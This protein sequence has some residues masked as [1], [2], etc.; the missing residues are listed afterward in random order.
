[1]SLSSLALI[2]PWPFG[3]PTA[4]VKEELVFGFGPG[5]LLWG[6]RT[7]DDN[8]DDE[9]DEGDKR[10]PAGWPLFGAAAA[11]VEFAVGGRRRL[12]ASSLASVRAARSSQGCRCVRDS[13]CHARFTPCATASWVPPAGAHHAGTAEAPRAAAAC[14]RKAAA[15]PP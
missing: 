13:A 8:D 12:A 11:E 14:T 2:K 10:L 15:G 4:T 6:P 5:R 1:M 9:E 7:N 3:M